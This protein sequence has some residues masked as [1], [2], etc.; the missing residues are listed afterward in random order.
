MKIDNNTKK[1]L[2]RVNTSKAPAQL[3]AEEASPSLQST[4]KYIPINPRENEFAEPSDR[5]LQAPVDLQTVE[6]QRRFFKT[7]NTSLFNTIAIDAFERDPV[8]RH[9]FQCAVFGIVANDLKAAAPENGNARDI[10]IAKD[11]QENVLNRGWVLNKLPTLHL[12]G[13]FTNAGCA[14]IIWGVEK[15]KYVIQ[16]IFN[17]PVNWV[18]YNPDDPFEIMFLPK[19]LGQDFQRLPDWKLLKHRPN[20]TIGNPHTGGF[21]Y[22]ITPALVQK[23]YIQSLLLVW[24]EKY[25]QPFV[26]AKTDTLSSNPEQLKKDRKAL[27]DGL[28]RLTVESFAILPK[29]TELDFI[30]SNSKTQADAYLSI[31]RYMDDN[32]KKLVLNSSVATDG[33]GSLELGQIHALEKAEFIKAQAK[34]LA[35]TV[36]EAVELYVR[37][38]YGENAKVPNIYFDLKNIENTVALIDSV[39]KLL[40]HG[41]EVSQAEIQQKLGLNQPRKGEKILEN[42]NN[43]ILPQAQNGLPTAIRDNGLGGQNKPADNAQQ[44]AQDNNNNGVKQ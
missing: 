34:I 11:V 44:Q 24:L 9:I 21:A 29:S 15:G 38:N 17:I 40:P 26:L 22:T 36:Q 4:N 31:L 5:G 2:F 39:S 28:K 10:D 16:D 35:H 41:L 20:L 13:L 14:E 3:E 18:C 30:D 33:K 19:D 37:F 1:D 32:I 12:S 25:S 42:I 43:N 27:T 23:R 8:V 6:R 7:L